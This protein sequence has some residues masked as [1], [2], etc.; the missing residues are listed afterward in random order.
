MPSVSDRPIN[1]AEYIEAAYRK[2]KEKTTIGTASHLYMQAIAERVLSRAEK[3]L[4][5]AEALLEGIGKDANLI[6]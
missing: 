2:A 1:K 4:D 3:F 6:G 5:S